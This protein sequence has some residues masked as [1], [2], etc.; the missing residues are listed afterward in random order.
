MSV[1]LIQEA[2]NLFT[3]EIVN[4][5]GEHLGESP[6]S[7]TTA[8]KGIVPSIF[9]SLIQKSST[10]AG[11]AEVAD[12]AV[13]ASNEDHSL[14]NLMGRFT[15]G[16]ET[17]GGMLSS[18]MGNLGGG[19]GLSSIISNFAGIKSSSAASLLGMAMPAIMGFIGKFF[20]SNNSGS[21]GNLLQ[22][23]KQ[24]VQ[25]EMPAGLNLSSILGGMGGATTAATMATPHTPHVSQSST[26]TH[27]IAE[28]RNGGG[29]KWLLP[30]LL[31]ALIGAG[32]LYFFKDGCN[33][34]PDTVNVGLHDKDSANM[35]N[36]TDTMN[37]M[38][39]ATTMGT[40][41]SA[42]DYVY[43]VGNMKSIT[44]PN[45]GGTI[46]VGENSTEARLVSFLMSNETV[47]ADKGNW[48]EFTNVKF[49]TGKATI[50]EE[51]M[52]Q[53]K[54]MMAIAKA[55]PK[56]QFKIGG[57]TDNTGAEALNMEISKNRAAAVAAKIKELGAG[58]ASIVGSDGYGP[59]FPVGDNNTAEGRA[60][61]R[62]VAVNVKAK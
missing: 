22:S 51:S 24:Y 36:G 16:N 4:K 42:G 8:L 11:E 44:L 6:S 50:K 48:F 43:N 59:Q 12:M 40:V 46:T 18:L 34:N 27:E 49:N 23:Q 3:N 32:A 56:A 20:K 15:S 14:S 38:P 10:P 1:N 13:Q 19:G 9:A 21:I 57:Y 31:L 58:A 30:V 54:N 7:I 53:L 29:L 35:N 33:K 25:D 28:E 52:Q 37:R 5:V 41:D 47:N 17:G 2:K 55:F 62:R 26:T 60:Q 61:N 45:D 39:P